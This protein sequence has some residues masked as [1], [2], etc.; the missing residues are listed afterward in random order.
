MAG[1]SRQAQREIEKAAI[2]ALKKR[3]EEKLIPYLKDNLRIDTGDM[4][5]NTISEIINEQGTEKLRVVIGEGL[6]YPQWLELKG[7]GALEDGTLAGAAFDDWMR[8]LD[9]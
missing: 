9:S 7:L 6:D 1:L 8:M 2:A 4:A 3:A 5:E